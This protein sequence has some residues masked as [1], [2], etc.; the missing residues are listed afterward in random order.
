MNSS[1]I[2]IRQTT[3]S[4]SLIAVCAA[5]LCVLSP[6]AVPTPFGVGFTLQVFAVMLTALLLK[7]MQ[8]LAAQLIYTLLGFIGLPVFSGY[9]SG[10]GILARPTG[11]F[12]IGFIIAAFCV[13]LLKGDAKNKY[14]LARYIAVSIAVGIPCIY[15]PGIIGFMLVTGSNF[16]TSFSLVAATFIPIDLA[17]C[18]LASLIALP[19]EKAIGVIRS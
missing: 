12:I 1:K 13:S 5:L 16:W 19:V 17:K 9:Q 3:I 18:T 2:N 14:A 11:G 10:V 8:A 6:L 7:P 15:L 4:L